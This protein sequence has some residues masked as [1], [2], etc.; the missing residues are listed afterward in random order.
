W[1]E[2]EYGTSQEGR[3]V[4]QLDKLEMGLQAQMYETLLK[5]DFRDFVTSAQK[6]VQ[7][8]VLQEIL[9]DKKK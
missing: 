6:T 1:R 8:P 3:F 9:M 2:F 4:Q 7:N 5:R